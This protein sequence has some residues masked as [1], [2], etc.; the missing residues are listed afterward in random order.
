MVD[1][2]LVLKQL[3]DRHDEVGVAEPAEYVVEHR[4]ILVLDALG[5]TVR[6]RRQHHAGNRRMRRLHLT[7]D[8]E[9]IV[10][11]ITRHTDHQVDVGSLQY[12]IG[13][14]RRRHLGE[15]RRIA[16]TEFHILIEDLLIDTSVVLQHEGVVGISHDEDIED[17]PRHQIDKRHILQIEFIPLLWYLGYF[18]HIVGKV[19]KKSAKAQRLSKIFVA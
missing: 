11:G 16:H 8:G 15:R 5:D 14:L 9:R 10:V 1:V 2:H 18:F 7:G 3:D 13:L 19:T 12:G 17:T 6:E 4:H